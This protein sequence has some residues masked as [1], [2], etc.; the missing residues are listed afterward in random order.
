M[1]I[2]C[3][4][5][6]DLIHTIS[7]MLI[8]FGYKFSIQVVGRTIQMW[9]AGCNLMISNIIMLNVLYILFYRKV[10]ENCKALNVN[11][12]INLISIPLSIGY[13]YRS[14]DLALRGGK[15]PLHAY[16]ENVCC[17]IF[18]IFNF[19]CYG[20][21]IYLLKRRKLYQLEVTASFEDKAIR[22]LVKRLRYYPLCQ[23]ITRFPYY[24]FLL[25]FGPNF[26]YHGDAE[27]KVYGIIILIGFLLEPIGYFAIFLTM[28]PA[29]FKYLITRLFKCGKVTSATTIS[30]SFETRPSS[31]SVE[32][33]GSIDLRNSVTS[34]GEPADIRRSSSTARASSVGMFDEIDLV[35]M[36]DSILIATLQYGATNRDSRSSNEGPMPMISMSP[37]TGA[38]FKFFT[39]ANESAQNPM[40][41]VFKN[42]SESSDRIGE[43]RDQLS[44]WPSTVIACRNDEL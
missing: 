6:Y 38:G 15:V 29:A 3:M 34:N 5:L 31:L 35:D 20:I 24:C 32:G 39:R 9:A 17:I 28:Q 16:I 43:S 4:T 19:I 8:P 11:I 14:G 37:V 10:W 21:M 23:A 27:M 33:R 18:V 26:F 1:L 7:L 30:T 40:N 42:T 13:I 44:E 25:V 2:F 36:S 41:S 22:E 12:V